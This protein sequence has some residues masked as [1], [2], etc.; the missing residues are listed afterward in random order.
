MFAYDA[1]C[2]Q[3]EA[4]LG[5]P[6]RLHLTAVWDSKLRFFESFDMKMVKMPEM[7]HNYEK[8]VVVT[9]T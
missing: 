6:A 9:K 3:I 8:R 1:L 2:S 4:S 7:P 5:N